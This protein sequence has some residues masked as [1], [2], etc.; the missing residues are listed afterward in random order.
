MLTE[1]PQIHTPPLERDVLRLRRMTAA[2]LNG[3][4]RY[5]AQVRAVVAVHGKAALADELG[6]EDAAALQSVYNSLKAAVASGS[7]A[8]VEEM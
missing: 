7:G 2:A 5:L 8:N 3:C 6:S 4:E 1:I